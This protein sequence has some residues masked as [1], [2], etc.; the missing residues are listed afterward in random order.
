MAE[1]EDKTVSTHGLAAC[2]EAWTNNSWIQIIELQ[3]RVCVRK[4]L[5]GTGEAR[6]IA[7]GRY[8]QEWSYSEGH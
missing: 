8:L 2:R 1:A 4:K 5:E 7:L 3:P 6:A